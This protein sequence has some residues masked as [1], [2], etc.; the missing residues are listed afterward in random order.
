MSRAGRDPRAI[1]RFFAK[2]EEKLGMKG[3]SSFL[4]THPGTAERRKAIDDHA[5]RIGTGGI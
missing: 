5:T 2:I 4:S 3:D 1:G